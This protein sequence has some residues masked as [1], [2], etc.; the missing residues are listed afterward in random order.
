MVVGAEDDDDDDD[1]PPSPSPLLP[2]FPC[3]S[4]RNPN[5]TMG[6]CFDATILLEAFKPL[7]NPTGGDGDENR[8]DFKR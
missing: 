6:C 8:S 4:S 1:P 7:E 3:S 2:S 5:I